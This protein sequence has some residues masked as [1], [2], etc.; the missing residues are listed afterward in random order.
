MNTPRSGLVETPNGSDCDT[1]ER[2]MGGVIIVPQFHLGCPTFSR[3][4][5]VTQPTKK[6]GLL[7][8]RIKRSAPIYINYYGAR[9]ESHL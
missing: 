3:K 1:S 5:W 6:K 2:V 4:F 8:G 9:G 7:L